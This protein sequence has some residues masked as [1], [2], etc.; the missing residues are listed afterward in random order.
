MI[1]CKIC[2]NIEERQF[3]EEVQTIM[4][5]EHLC[6]ECNFWREQLQIDKQYPSDFVIVNGVHYRIG[7]E[8]DTGYFRGFSGHKFIIKFNDGREKVTTNLWCQGQI[9]DGYWRERMPDNAKFR[10]NIF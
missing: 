9:P 3:V 2:G 8:N 7:P 1:T 4:E 6:Y 10:E 5:K